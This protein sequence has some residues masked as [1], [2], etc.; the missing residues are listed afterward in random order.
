MCTWIY[1]FAK[2][3][4]WTIHLSEN[5][6]S[7]SGVI[8]GEKYFFNKSAMANFSF[9]FKKIILKESITLKILKKQFVESVHEFSWIGKKVA[10]TMWI[11]RSW[12]FWLFCKMTK[13]YM[14]LNCTI[15]QLIYKTFT[16]SQHFTFSDTLKNACPPKKSAW[17]YY[18]HPPVNPEHIPM[19]SHNASYPWLPTMHHTHVFPQCI[20]QCLPTMHHDRLNFIPV[21]LNREISFYG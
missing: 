13:I 21:S 8:F 9:S 6:D 5:F 1:W 20:I 3:I 2:K 18:Q 11:H 12:V 15:W 16:I 14:Q 19:P 7:I 4:V 17:R 10:C